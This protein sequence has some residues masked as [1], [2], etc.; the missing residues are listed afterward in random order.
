MLALTKDAVVAVRDVLAAEELP[1]E[2]GVRIS[3]AETGDE[4]E[5]GLSLAEAPAE[6]DKVIDEDGARVFLDENAASLLDDQVL[7][8]VV[9]DDH[10]HFTF[11]DQQAS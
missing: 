8:A 2:A 3:T 4:T 10:F 7:D 6:G 1:D 11:R 9:H 5:F